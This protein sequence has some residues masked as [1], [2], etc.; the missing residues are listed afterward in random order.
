MS[1]VSLPW[2]GENT[3][4]KWKVEIF[5]LTTTV[6]IFI[7]YMDI[8]TKDRSRLSLFFSFLSFLNHAYNSVLSIYFVYFKS[9]SM[10]I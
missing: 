2:K 4:V 10:T 7:I 6:P 5:A 8:F 3:K 9:S 1:I